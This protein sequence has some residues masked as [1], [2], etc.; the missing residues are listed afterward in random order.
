MSVLRW[1]CRR[2]WN[3]CRR[4]KW[5]LGGWISATCWRPSSGWPNLLRN[6]YG[7]QAAGGSG[8]AG[9]AGGGV[10]VLLPV[11]SPVV[12]TGASALWHCVGDSG[13]GCAPGGPA[14]LDAGGTG[15][16]RV[17]GQ[18]GL[19]S[20]ARVLGEPLPAGSVWRAGGD[21]PRSCSSLADLAR[22]GHGP[23]A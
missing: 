3:F 6:D 22:G 8:R 2:C 10:R 7:R 14:D 4:V 21:C 19:G 18:D 1:R 17:R 5:R 13:G 11:A 9:A 16:R 23:V 20:A 12:A 15:G